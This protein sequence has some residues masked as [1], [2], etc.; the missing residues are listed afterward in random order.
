M[1]SKRFACHL[2]EYSSDAGPGGATLPF[3]AAVQLQVDVCDLSVKLSRLQVQVQLQSVAARRGPTT[4]SHWQAGLPLAVLTRTS[5][6]AR[7]KLFQVD[8]SAQRAQLCIRWYGSNG[9]GRVQMR[10]TRAVTVM[11]AVGS[12]AVSVAV[13]STEGHM[14]CCGRACAHLCWY[15]D[16]CEQSVVVPAS[17]DREFLSLCNHTIRVNVMTTRE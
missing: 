16:V 8:S 15:R 3:T 14:R 4:P 17:H 7:L 13:A 12:A 11:T 10:L 9:Q 5:A 1:R 6:M 2:N